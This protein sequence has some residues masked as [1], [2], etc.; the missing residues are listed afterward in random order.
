[1][2]ESL[3]H[4]PLHPWH[5][6]RGGRMVGFAGWSM[7]VQYES[8]SSEHHAVRNADLIQGTER[9]AHFLPSIS[10]PRWLNMN[11]NRFLSTLRS[12]VFRAA[13]PL[14]C[15]LLFAPTA[16]AEMTLNSYDPQVHNRYNSASFLGDAFDWSG[17]AIQA[18]GSA[19]W[20]TMISNQRFISATHSHP[21]VGRTLVFRE[22]NT[23][24]GLSHTRMVTVGER[25]LNTDL[26]IG[27][28]DAP[29]PAAIAVYEIAS[30]GIP[31]VT[32][33]LGV[34]ADREIYAVGEIGNR[35]VAVGRNAYDGSDASPNVG[36]G[37]F[38]AVGFVE[39]VNNGNPNFKGDDESFHS[40]ETSPGVF[41]GGDSGAPSFIDDGGTLKL[42]GIHSYIVRDVTS[43]NFSPFF[44]FKTADASISNTAKRITMDNFVPNYQTEINGVL[45]QPIPEPSSAALLLLT[46]L[47]GAGWLR[48]RRA[49]R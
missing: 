14:G 16:R 7:P 8:I 48:R 17:V 26:W 30:P 1:M 37:V 29:L 42:T 49:T 41:A 35:V 3:K 27:T 25:I 39:D 28:L 9:L 5:V 23:T 32:T 38:D 43:T 6:D 20:A 11:C 36:L 21:A 4:T 47:A 15:F 31:N 24:T 22:D 13:I 33:G 44:H 18:A 10:H 12:V 19:R 40:A 2:A 45:A 46:T 34:Y